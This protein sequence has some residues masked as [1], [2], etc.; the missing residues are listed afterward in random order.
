M[1]TVRRMIALAELALLAVVDREQDFVSDSQ[2]RT[3]DFRADGADYTGAFVAEDCWEGTDG[4][5]AGLHDEVRVADSRVEHFDQEFGGL[6]F[7]QDDFFEFEV[8]FGVVDDP[9]RGGD[10]GGLDLCCHGLGLFFLW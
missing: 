8:F 2:V 1:D 6:H 4:D 9:G 3:V 10:V 7:V 5:C